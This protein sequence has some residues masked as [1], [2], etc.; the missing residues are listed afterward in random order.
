MT[1][2]HLALN[3]YLKLR[4]KHGHDIAV[5]RMTQKENDEIFNLILRN[6][7]VTENWS[8]ANDGFI[9]REDV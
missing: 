3:K 7:G 9:I 4:E 6:S 5:K 8:K 2:K 1:V